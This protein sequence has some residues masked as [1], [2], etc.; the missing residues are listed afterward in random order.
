M[1]Q[2]NN[3]SVTLS[4]LFGEQSSSEFKAVSPHFM[5]REQ[6]S[7]DSNASVRSLS[8]IKKLKINKKVEKFSEYTYNGS[9]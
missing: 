7:Y 1:K 2:S 5:H 6:I 3:N 9:I 8:N 4:N